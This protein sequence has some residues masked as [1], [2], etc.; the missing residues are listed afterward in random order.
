MMKLLIGIP[1]LFS[2]PVH[3]AEEIKIARKRN[4]QINLEN[5]NKVEDSVANN[6]FEISAEEEA[7]LERFLQ[8][9]S[10]SFS[11]PTASPT[12]APVKA[13]V[14]PTRSPTKRPTRS[15]STNVSNCVDDPVFY[16]KYEMRTC[17]F[18]DEI[19]WKRDKY[20]KFGEVY[21]NCPRTCGACCED[22]TEDQFSFTVRNEARSCWWI[23]QKSA[24]KR[25]YCSNSVSGGIISDFCPDACG[26]C[27]TNEIQPTSSP[28]AVCS[29]DDDWN[30]FNNEDITCKWIRNTEARRQEYCAKGSVVTDNCPQSC[31]LCCADH[32]G[33]QFRDFEREKDI[34]CDYISKSNLRKS[35]Y[36][37]LWR[38]ETMVRDV[39]PVACDNCFSAVGPT[40][41][42][43]R[44]SNCQNND[45]YHWFRAP[46]VTC[47][48]IRNE[49]SRRVDFCNRNA[50]VKENCPQSCGVCCSNDATYSLDGNG[51]R[52]CDWVAAKNSRINEYCDTYQNDRMVRDA[53]PVACDRCLDPV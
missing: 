45:D 42:P 24:R 8:T 34:T 9:T 6:E 39:C 30:F 43:T 40:P 10:L 26:I 53:C 13:P 35:R 33:Y 12:K 25:L 22:S 14:T 36:C 29:N 23:A 52:D 32:S 2:L 3:G 38:E 44:S 28:V 31:G 15:P 16:H 18:I 48:W 20:C 19:Q 1:L 37:D 27:R 49:E 7:R 51:N 4:I 47:K 21:E 50:R 46:K 5:L 11:M 41:S 17:S